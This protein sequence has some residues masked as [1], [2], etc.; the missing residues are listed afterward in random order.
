MSKINMS[1]LMDEV[2][3]IN[4][5]I[6]GLQL[7]LQNKK[8][9]IAKYFQKTGNKNI[10]GDEAT[11]FQ[12]E[13]TK[14]EYDVPMILATL[15]KD[16]TS[17]FID[18]SY[19]IYDWKAFVQFCKSKGINPKE[20]KQFISVSSSVNQQKLNNLYERGKITL[21]DLEG[22]YEATVTKSVVIRFKNIEKEI[23][24]R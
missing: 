22:C 24:V 16:L 15:P 7:L 12:Q 11:A 19:S 6:Q 21:K 23:P 20:L 9:I 4:N 14:V 5:Q 18:K 1:Q 2:V 13:R 17:Q 10:N 8:S 3:H